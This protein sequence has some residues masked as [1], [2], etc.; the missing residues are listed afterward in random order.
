MTT[1]EDY[2]LLRKAYTIR[3]VGDVSGAIN[4]LLNGLGMNVADRFA[5][6]FENAVNRSGLLIAE[7]ST[8]GGDGDSIPSP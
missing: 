2:I 3:D 5:D 8:T 4:S 6:F 1:R 7:A